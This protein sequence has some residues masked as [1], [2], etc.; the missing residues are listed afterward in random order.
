MDGAG[1][2]FDERGR[3]LVD[4]D[5]VSSATTATYY[6]GEHTNFYPSDRSL[7][8]RRFVREHIA[9]GLMPDEPLF[10]D[11]A[12][13]VPFGSCFA[14][15]IADYLFRLDYNVSTRRK[16]VSYLSYMGDGIVNTYALRQQFEWAWLDRRPAADVWHGQDLKALGFG[17]DVRL[18]TKNLFDEADLFII[19]LGLSEVWYDGPTGEVFWRAVPIEYFDPSRHKFRLSTYDD[20]LANLEAIVDLIR[21]HRPSAH[22]LF[23]LSP[24]PLTATFRPIPCAVADA[25]SKAILRAAVGQLMRSRADEKLHYFP[26]YEI[27]QR[28]FNHAYRIDR[29]HVHPYV[30]EFVMKV[31]ERYYCMSG[32]TDEA[33]LEAFRAAR[34]I[35][36]RVG[37]EG[38]KAAPQY[39]PS[40]GRPHHK[41]PK[42]L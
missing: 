21:A 28:F 15:H 30:V 14:Y 6:R 5:G 16:S 40:D 11:K 7:E 39:K 26:S 29:I 13:I 37:A 41:S 3:M 31:F 19:T 20:N 38:H 33:L 23:T 24:V 22:I 42:V 18:A 35:D 2:A 17:E 8:S 34:E 1:I 12:S 4:R 9:Q 36:R 10:D 25:E 32:T 27:V